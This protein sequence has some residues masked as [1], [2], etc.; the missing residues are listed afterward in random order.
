[1]VSGTDFENLRN[2]GRCGFIGFVLS[3]LLP[4][5]GSRLDVP[6]VLHHVMV[7]GMGERPLFRDEADR[8]DFLTCL[9][10]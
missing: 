8:R 3:D 4:S 1:M 10:L 9:A 2:G 7:Q 6:G 5:R